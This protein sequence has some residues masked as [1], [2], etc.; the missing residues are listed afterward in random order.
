MPSEKKLSKVDL[1]VKLRAIH[2]K[3]PK[4]GQV[5]A[6]ETL[7]TEEKDVILIAKTGYG[8]S[9]MFHSVLILKE[10]IITLMIMPLLALKNIQK[11]AIKKMQAN[12]NLY[13]LN[14]KTM[15]KNLLNKIQLQAGWVVK[16]SSATSAFFCHV[17]DHG[18]HSPKENHCYIEICGVRA[19]SWHKGFLSVCINSVGWERNWWG[20]YLGSTNWRNKIKRQ[21][22]YALCQSPPTL[23]LGLYSYSF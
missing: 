20:V 13:I 9:M 15:M 19:C 7:F 6:I 4:A 14:S 8:K 22:S 16:C 10:D 1:E 5:L 2:G 11:Q 23:P 18:Q 12:S 21:M 17:H 3:T